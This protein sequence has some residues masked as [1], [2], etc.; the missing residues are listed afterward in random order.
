MSSMSI[1]YDLGLGRVATT[2]KMV[3]CTYS[4]HWDSIEYDYM[5]KSKSIIKLSITISISVLVY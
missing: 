5:S 2:I 1:V 3:H 4:T